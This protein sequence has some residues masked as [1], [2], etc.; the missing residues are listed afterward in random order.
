MLFLNVQI[1]NIV[2]LFCLCFKCLSDK[3]YFFS[4]DFLDTS[5]ILSFYP[6]LSL[7]KIVWGGFS[8]T[9]KSM[10]PNTICNSTPEE[11]GS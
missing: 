9:C 8:A 11:I 10:N 5:T 4:F 2:F 7:F 3:Y 6:F 1:V